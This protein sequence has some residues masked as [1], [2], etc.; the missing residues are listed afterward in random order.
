MDVEA[1][2]CKRD[3]QSIQ[4][5][6][7]TRD[8]QDTQDSGDVG[9]TRPAASLSAH[10]HHAS[11]NVSA[12]ASTQVSEAIDV[13][14]HAWYQPWPV[15]QG[16]SKDVPQGVP[17][18]VSQGVP[19]GESQD[20]SQDDVPQGV[21][22][23]A[24]RASGYCA[25]TS[26]YD[27]AYSPA[28]IYQGLLHDVAYVA[29]A[30]EAGSSFNGNNHSSSRKHRNPGKR[31]APS[32]VESID[33]DDPSKKKRRRKRNYTSKLPPGVNVSRIDHQGNVHAP[34]PNYQSIQRPARF[35]KRLAKHNVTERN[36]PWYKYN[37]EAAINPEPSPGEL[38][39]ASLVQTTVARFGGGAAHRVCL[40]G[41][42]DT[43][44]EHTLDETGL[45]LWELTLWKPYHVLS[46]KDLREFFYTMYLPFRVDETKWQAPWS[47]DEQEEEDT[48]D[49][50]RDFH[51]LIH[52]KRMARYQGL[53][54]DTPTLKTEPDQKYHLIAHPAHFAISGVRSK[55]S[56]K[57]SLPNYIPLNYPMLSA[58]ELVHVFVQFMR[59]GEK[60][61]WQDLLPR[62][63]EFYP[64]IAGAFYGASGMMHSFSSNLNNTATEQLWH[65]SFYVLDRTLL[66]DTRD[67]SMTRKTLSIDPLHPLL[68]PEKYADAKKGEPQLRRVRTVWR[69]DALGL[70][71]GGTSQRTSPERPI[72]RWCTWTKCM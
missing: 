25:S 39:L 32:P 36:H 35:A 28:P 29:K 1:I 38:R 13:P 52:P 12:V 9:G 45:F 23:D 54:W 33:P 44:D 30:F 10:P 60:Y 7:D 70:G 64:E 65:N 26:P 48:E 2:G 4:T 61:V 37:I 19:Q 18:D 11:D 49:L 27:D 43:K 71:C 47:N 69:A 6:Q 21:P 51:A 46:E 41:V 17:P 22:Q 57:G 34:E 55:S 40:M 14:L 56:K 24:F 3:A 58:K 53:F 67:R 42:K 62:V 5:I 31:R 20:V 8:I 59:P 72:C 63:L 16:G 66:Q 15:G 50:W 68:H